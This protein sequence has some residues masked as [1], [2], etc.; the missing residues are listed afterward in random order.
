MIKSKEYKFYDF[1]IV[2]SKIIPFQTLFAVVNT[3][4]GSLIPAYQTLVIAQFINTAMDIFYGISPYSSI[5]TPL[6]LIMVYVIYSNIISSIAQVFD[7]S[8]RNKLNAIM[9]KEFALKQARFA[10]KHIENNDTLEIINRACADP[11]GQFMSGLNNI[12]SAV[13]L[14]V[15]SISLLIIVMTANVLSGLIIIIISVPLFYIAL[16]TGK[17]NYEMGMDA[18]KIQ[19][20]YNYLS[21]ILT[22]REN[23]EERKLFNYSN[24]LSKQYKK[25]YEDSYKIERKIEIKSYANAKS[26]SMIT[27]LI[28]FIIVALLIPS[29]A[30][31]KIELGLFIA[32]VN[33][34]YGLVQTMSWQLSNTMR[35]FARLKEYLKDVSFFA[36]LSEKEGA[37]SIKLPTND[38]TFNTLEFKNVSFK[39]PG[40][41]KWILK[42]CS[43]ILNHDKNY[44]FVGVNG[45]GKTTIIKLLTGMYDEYEG[46]ILIND[47]N[48]RDYKYG[49]I[50]NI[51]SVVF[52]DYKK[53]ALTIKDN[54]IIG[55]IMKINDKKLKHIIDRM[56]LNELINNLQFGVDTYLGKIKQNSQDLSGGQW[57]RLALA[58]LLYSEAAINILD[59]P[60]AALD[61]MAESKVYDLFS[62]INHNKFTIFVTHR[63][64]AA[65]IAD[66]IL[67][68]DDGK[69]IEHASHDELMK[70]KNGLYRKMF[71]S[72][73]SWYEYKNNEIITELN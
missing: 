57:Q 55:D 7:M 4:I 1:L 31:N 11:A 8:G 10:Y 39:Y 43:F 60:T 38:F 36:N 69:I 48:I 47:K 66:E 44:S 54:I 24:V 65:R 70:M 71:E 26:G 18:Q 62:K 56:S 45:A 37:C 22:N 63:L 72:Q 15:S 6:I 41:D 68:I 3:I 73:K 12:L 61:P 19:R 16:K 25:L 33:A 9:R 50:K 27:L 28:I 64:G 40:T 13:N 51:I 52:Q 49:E 42:K 34:I 58:R 32:L 46:D 23:A 21:G 2:P 30:N 29:L 53:Y 5:F 14:I 20:R 17:K 67:V 35:E 59:E